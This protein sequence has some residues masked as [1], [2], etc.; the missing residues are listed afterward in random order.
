[1]PGL[2][3]NPTLPSLY[4]GGVSRTAAAGTGML[5]FLIVKCKQWHNMQGTMSK[6]ESIRQSTEDLMS[7]VYALY[8][9]RGDPRIPW[10]AKAIIVLTVVYALS[11]IDLIPDFIPYLGY[12]DDL[13]IIP[14]GIALA[15]HFMPKNVW[16]EYRER[17]KA[18]FA[19]IK[20]AS[21]EGFLIILFII[22]EVWI[23]LAIGLITFI[24][25]CIL[26][27]VLYTQQGLLN[28]GTIIGVLGLAILFITYEKFRR[29]LNAWRDKA[30][31]LRK[32]VLNKQ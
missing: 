16:E 29:K 10:Y 12:L 23:I 8:L 30:Q 32:N 26:M 28:I 1:M 7:D 14:A 3:G 2:S 5:G 27:A 13:V 6:L 15:I 9:A 4:P 20:L 24:I 25:G 31:S 11:P 18:G 17:A 21:W 22:R 19:T